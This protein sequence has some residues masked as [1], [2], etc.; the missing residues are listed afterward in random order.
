MKHDSTLFVVE[1]QSSQSASDETT[2]AMF[3]MSNGQ[4]V[5][6]QRT[7]T[8]KSLC[9]TYDRHDVPLE[10]YYLEEK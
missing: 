5:S 3:L 6:V 1:S 8:L 2:Y 9:D 4:Y 7:S 10:I